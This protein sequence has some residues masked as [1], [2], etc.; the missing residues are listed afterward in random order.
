[1]IVQYLLEAYRRLEAAAN[2]DKTEEQALAFE[3]EIADIQLLGSSEQISATVKYLRSHASPDGAVIDEVLFLLRK[4][5]RN[6]ALHHPKG[7]RSFSALSDTTTAGIGKEKRFLE[8]IVCGS[9]RIDDHCLA[10]SSFEL[11]FA[12]D[13]SVIEIKTLARSRFEA[14]AGYARSPKIVLYIEEIEWYAT[15]DERL[16]GMLERDRIDHD[17]GWVIVG[18]DERLRFRA[19][20]VNASLPSPE[21]ARQQLFERMKEEYEKPDEAY[22]QGDAP[23]RPTDFFTPLV[24]EERLNRLFKILSSEERYS[25]ARKLI[26]AM[27]RFYEDT[28]GNFV[29]QFQTTAF[30]ARIWELYLFATF[31]EL[32]YARVPD[33]AVPD[34][35]F[36]SPFGRVGVEATSASPPTVGDVKPPSDKAEFIAYIE[37]YVPIKLARVLQRKLEKKKPYWDA[38]EMKDVPFI[39]AVQD[40]HSPGAMRMITSAMTEYVFGVR[41]ISTTALAGSNGSMNMCGGT[42]AK[43]QDFLNCQTPRTSVP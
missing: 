13:S 37:N 19:I 34:F 21:A 10:L 36:D 14:L 20:D 23:G 17:F 24:P 41:H 31:T 8:L 25:P 22:H 42:D 5:L 1:M 9:Q 30:D 11:G 33:L 43:N 40:F 39:I 15:P 38:V 27:M 3:S 32:G 6:L 26:E 2:R 28:D 16:I 29:E 4:D 18:R 35:L 7:I 12:E